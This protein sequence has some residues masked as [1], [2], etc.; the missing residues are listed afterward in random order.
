[1]AARLVCGL[2][3][4]CCS[5]SLVACSQET[6]FSAQFMRY[7]TLPNGDRVAVVQPVAAGADPAEI[8]AFTTISDLAPGE[9]VYVK[10]TGRSWDEPQWSP[11]AAVVDRAGKPDDR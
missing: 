9:I 11:E 8:V 4:L 5:L 2:F 7:D 6:D 10:V 3:L 1:M